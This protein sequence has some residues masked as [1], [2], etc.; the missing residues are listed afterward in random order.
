MALMHQAAEKGGNAL[1]AEDYVRFNRW[2][3]LGHWLLAG[4]FL[5][6]VATGLP[7]KFNDA[8]LS[9][10]IINALGGID[11]ARFIHRILACIF[12]FQSLLHLAEIGLSILRGRF[13]PS[14]VITLHDFRDAFDMLRYSVGLI[15]HKPQPDRYD[16]RQKFE[17]WGIVFGAII[18]IA[19]GLMLWFP[20]YITRVLPGELVP[21]AKEMHSGEALLALLVIVVWH[22]YDVVL[23]PSVFPLDTV[24]ITGRMSRERLLEE[25]PREYARLLASE[26]LA[27]PRT[28]EQPPGV[29]PV[30]GRG[31]PGGRIQ[32]GGPAAAEAAGEVVG[33]GAAR[34]GAI[35]RSLQWRVLILVTIGMAGTLA[36]FSVSSLLAV[37][38]SIDR[39]LDERQALAQASAGQVDYVVRQGLTVL[40][41]PADG[42]G[43]DL[44]D[45]DAEPERQAL[46]RVLSGSIFTRVYLTDADGEVLWTEPLYPSVL[47]VNIGFLPHT[48][49]A[50]DSGR[51]SVS[52]LSTAL[53]SG[54]PAVSMVA[55]VRGVSGQVAGLIA[56]DIVLSETDLAELIQPAA[57][58]GTGYAQI[59]DAQG[60]VLASTLPGQLLEKSDH[61]GQIAKLIEEK[62]ASSGTCHGCHDS[63]GEEEREKEVMAFA[64]ME[65]APWGVLIRQSE[66][67]ALA[68]ADRLRE[69]ALWF[70]VPAFG[71][72]LLFAWVT[73]RSVLRPVR[74]LTMAVEKISAG[75]L[76]QAV[77][78]LGEDEIGSL[79]RTFEAMRGRL[80]ESRDSIEAWGRQ[81]EERVQERT[82]ELEASRDHLR[83]VAG[84]NAALFEELTRKE[85]ARSE[86]LKK[87][88]RAQE[89]ERRRIARELHDETSQA[90]TAL[91][92][93]METAA[94]APEA[95]RARFQKKLTELKELA[96]ETL[97]DV[98]RL[99]YDLRPSVL[100]DLGL[101]AGLR[102]Y[103]DS[104]LQSAGV[105]VRVSVK[106]DEKRLPAEVESTLFRIGQEAISNATRH[107]RA[108]DV[109][110]ALDFQ[111]GSIT[112]EVKD[113]GVGFDVAS[114]TNSGGPR[115]GW[116]I[117]GMQERATLLGGTLQI[118]SE[119][120][121]GT[122]VKVSIP[123]GEESGDDAE[124]SRPHSR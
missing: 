26:A 107:A 1:Q 57:V 23:S 101:V 29:L 112:L 43:L 50:L 75:D 116:G 55:P 70:G 79:A 38:E 92:V 117:L 60:T 115:P 73:A 28:P 100:D 67:E 2:H 104:R 41:E 82:R 17:Y 53:A 96:V 10:W 114:V 40:E 49:A 89:E 103:A 81:L 87:V 124:D 97:E 94:M 84:E 30:R 85:A 61:E 99:I 93:G 71:L 20:T 6:L 98:H 110:M 102:W 72:A 46:R 56:G 22:I 58:G 90:L 66:D 64:P 62:R 54:E 108:T 4:C 51:P 118:E 19:T 48:E 34:T 80:K 123:L 83:K 24:M 63:A 8:G 27:F 35:R 109:L 76:S 44:E 69:R 65:V 11:N 12:I 21:T 15:P 18:M 5:A 14:M 106:G 33:P 119:P 77:P 59:V 86:L 113:D 121:K 25:H 111:D 91:V 7:Q 13:R 68:P 74:V 120:G 9:V 88:I 36:A 45:E 31:P 16:Y 3:R 122:H 105:Q 42:E 37:N 32:A 47:G 78:S 39:T 95:E 52:G